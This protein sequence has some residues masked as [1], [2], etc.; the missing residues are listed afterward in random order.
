[1]R[2]NGRNT[3]QNLWRLVLFFVCLVSAQGSE[4][5]RLV[6]WNLEWFP[7]KKPAASLEQRDAHFREVAAVLPQFRADVIVLQE[8]RN[9]E[10]AERLAKLIPGFSVHVVSRFKDAFTHQLGEQQICIMSR[11]KAD[12]AWAEPWKRGWAKAPRG[13]AYAK[14][15]IEGKPLHVYGLH[16]KSNLGNP[17]ENTSKREDAMDQLLDH[18]TSQTKPKEPVIECGDFNTSKEQVNLAGDT[19][20]TKFEKAG[21]FWTFDGVPLEQ[22]IT[23]PGKGK[24]P[25][26]CFDHI[27]T[28]NLAKP[29][30]TV[31]LDTPGSDHFPVEIDFLL[32]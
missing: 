18:V 17:I 14:L 4:V 24:N 11:F 13:Y 29:V 32:R 30:A 23:V 20:L 1:M 3:M 7:G 12:A 8:I 9:D 25:D 26:A 19:T 31:L 16:L 10:A 6:T 15:L 5:I 22:R 21:F 2:T 28:S 27:Y